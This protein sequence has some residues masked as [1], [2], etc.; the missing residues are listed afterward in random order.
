MGQRPVADQRLGGASIADDQQR[1]HHPQSAATL[2]HTSWIISKATQQRR[3]ELLW[4][5]PSTGQNIIPQS[6]LYPFTNPPPT[7][8]LV[9]PTNGA[10][11]TASAS[12]TIGADADAP[13]NPIGTVGFY[14]NGNLIGT[15]SN[16]IYAPIYAMTSTGL[17]TGNYTLTAVA[18]DGSG[19]VSTS[20]PVT[21]TVTAGSGLPYGLTTNGIVPAFLNMP[22]TYNG[23]LPPLLSGTGVFGD[24][25][26]RAPA[27]GLIPYSLNLPL[28]SDGAVNSYFLAVAKPRRHHHAGRADRDFARPIRGNFPTAPSSSKISTYGG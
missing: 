4:S 28:W 20:A 14:A 3:G 26:R 12:V 18:T 9:Q 5:S 17:E 10:T 15:L 7:I 1:L 22:A 24:T 23:T 16:S 21:I 25:A 8:A 6:Q 13:Y 19:L 27:G 2:Q 11:Y